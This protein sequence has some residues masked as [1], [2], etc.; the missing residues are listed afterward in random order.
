MFGLGMA[1]CVFFGIP[2]STTF[3]RAISNLKL[4][5]GA[6]I[7]APDWGLV[8]NQPTRG[9]VVGSIEYIHRCI[10]EKHDER[11]AVLLI[12]ADYG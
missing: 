7:F 4:V 2:Y 1:V 10:I 12:S 9:L 8:A 5:L 11:C 6:R 3:P